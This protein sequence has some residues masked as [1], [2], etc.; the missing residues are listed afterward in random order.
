MKQI[1]RLYTEY[2]FSCQSIKQTIKQII[3][4]SNTNTTSVIMGRKVFEEC[5]WMTEGHRD[6][7]ITYFYNSNSGQLTYAASIFKRPTPDHV[8]TTVEINGH[9][10]TTTR[11]YTLRPANLFTFPKMDYDALIAEI[12]HCMIHGPGCKGPKLALETTIDTSDSEY[13]SESDGNESDGNESERCETPENTQYEVAPRT[14][15][16]RTTKKFAYYM[17][18]DEPFQGCKQTLREFMVMYKG[19]P[20]T[21]DVLYG[22]SISRRGYNSDTEYLDTDSVNKHFHTAQ[23]RLDKCPVQMNIESEYRHQLLKNAPHD[24]DVMYS[25]M[26]LIYDRIGGRFQIKGVRL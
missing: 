15:M 10:H 16:L 18:S 4:Y 9:E 19:S 7:C 14:F 6:I 17:V 20:S 2:Y 25:I 1:Y 21:G 3:M 22:A 26:D 5:M 11:R 12:R 23:S 24:E 13:L 8:M